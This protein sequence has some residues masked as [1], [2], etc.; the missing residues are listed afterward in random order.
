MAV[1]GLSRFDEQGR[2][3][4]APDPVALPFP[5]AKGL[6]PDKLAPGEVCPGKLTY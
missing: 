3:R 6:F 5:E 1:L 4:L 2:S